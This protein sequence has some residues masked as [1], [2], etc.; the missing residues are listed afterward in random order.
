MQPDPIKLEQI[1]TRGF[2]LIPGL[3][4][5]AQAADMRALLQTFVDE[6]LKKW[7]GRDYPD[8]WMV[9]NLMFRGL[10]FARLLEH[11]EMH[12][13]LSA[14]LGDTCILYACTSSSLPPRATNLSNRVH[15]DCPARDSRLH[16][17][18]GR[19]VRAG[20]VHGRERRDVL[21][22]GLDRASRRTD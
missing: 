16:H 12:A 5:A 2:A 18:R 20:Q 19:H 9:H 14:L 13:Y 6:D 8:R 7:E 3:L 4:T 21:P 17:E 1:K 10:P 22:A 11:E 15:V